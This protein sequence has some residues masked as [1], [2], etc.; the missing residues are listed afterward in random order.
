MIKILSVIAGTLLIIACS[1]ANVVQGD[2]LVNPFTFADLS[3]PYEYKHRKPGCGTI[4]SARPLWLSAEETHTIATKAFEDEGIDLQ[5]D[6]LY[7]KDSL[8]VLLD[9]FDPKLNIGYIYTGLWDV[10]YYDSALGKEKVYNS[11][12]L[13]DAC[14][15]GVERL[16]KNDI[17]KEILYDI[18]SLEDEKE[19]KHQYNNLG[20][21]LTTYDDELHEIKQKILASPDK[22]TIAKEI[23]A[24]G[25]NFLDPKLSIREARYLENIHKTEGDFIAMID[26]RDKR[27]SYLSAFLGH[28]KYRKIKEEKG[29]EGLREA[30]KEEESRKKEDHTKALKSF[31]THVR[32]Y[33]QW[34]KQEQGH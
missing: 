34:A 8:S 19:I 15:R 4:S 30:W 1:L 28:E 7:E 22:A 29:K 27:F 6:Y 26:V 20:I 18:I 9:G 17:L 31:E 23:Q 5:K 13:I 3:A 11:S 2:S 14:K 21:F 10:Q 24:F 25:F 16:D 12:L 32:Q 33:I